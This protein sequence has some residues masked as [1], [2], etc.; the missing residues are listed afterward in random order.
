MIQITSHQQTPVGETRDIPGG[1]KAWRTEYIGFS[2]IRPD[3]AQGWMLESSPQR[4]LRA[5]YHEVDQFQVVVE[6]EGLMGKHRVGPGVVHF[7]RAHTPY[8]PIVWGDQGM[9]LLTIRPRPD[10]LGSP[11]FMPESRDKLRHIPRNA[12]QV[13]HQVDLA[14][15]NEAV[16]VEP[17][18]GMQDDAGLSA[19]AYTLK[20]G[21]QT[22]APDPSAGGG[23]WILVM[24][25]SLIHEGK[26]YPGFSIAEVT[27]DE[28]AFR[29]QA[30]PDG[31]QAIVLSFSRVDAQGVKST[32]IG[33][34]AAKAQPA[35]TRTWLCELCGFIYDEAAG[36]P[37]EGIAA[38]TRWE[39]VP[40]A[41]GCPDCS[42]TKADFR[43]VEL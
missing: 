5:H 42:G 43:M 6:G 21:G 8:G 7:S 19:H 16:H 9:Q 32:A 13:S 4:V 11:Q 27:P 36:M 40:E 12:Y 20:P 34:K 15:K 28:S 25:G 22:L 38:G 33:A 23:Q 41:W 17:L 1:H 10:T 37:E 14:E 26:S 29:L 31:L 35:A 18:P 39:D 3:R 24:K 2:P 30:G